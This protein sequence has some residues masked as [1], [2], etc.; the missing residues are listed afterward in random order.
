M[1][2]V[3]SCLCRHAWPEVQY[4]QGFDA[5]SRGGLA[6]ARRARNPGRGARRE[7]SEQPYQAM[8]GDVQRLKLLAEPH[9][10]TLRYDKFLYGMQKVRG[11]NPLSSTA[12]YSRFSGDH[13]HV[14]V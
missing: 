9:P 10:A 14:W 8:P 11:S 3:F 5:L 4:D 1:G 13:F 7:A 6:V 2:V 12:W